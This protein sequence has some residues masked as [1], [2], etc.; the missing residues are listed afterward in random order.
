MYY[1]FIEAMRASGDWIKNAVCE[2]EKMQVSLSSRAADA[3]Q[4][5]PENDSGKTIAT[6]AMKNG[7]DLCLN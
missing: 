1:E 2:L 7:L 5:Q 6:I 4:H 3:E